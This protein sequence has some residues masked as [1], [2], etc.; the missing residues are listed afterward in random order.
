MLGECLAPTAEMGYL[1]NVRAPKEVEIYPDAGTL[2]RAAANYFVVLAR[3]AL[4]AH[5]RFGVALAGGATPQAMYAWLATDEFA[6]HVDW[7]RVHLFWGDERCVAPDHPDS[8]YRMVRQAWLDH[9]S[10]PADNVHRIQGEIEPAQA[11]ADYEQVLRTFFSLPLVGPETHNKPPPPRFDLILLGMGD[12]G[13]T[14]SLFPGAAA[15]RERRRWVVADYV[16]KLGAWR[17]T[18]AP[19][20][21]N[22][23]ADVIFLVSGPGKAE[24]LRQ[25]LAEPHQPDRLPAQIVRP[26]HGRLRWLVDAAAAT[27]LRRD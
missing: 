24:R 26:A 15:I 3:E 17:V 12:D 1:L 16:E 6:T 20:V 4:A 11:A 7:Q 5:G 13:H 18:L 23:A 25:V 22:A 9:V 21:I 19:A 10:I 27:L 2:A 14:A 8:N